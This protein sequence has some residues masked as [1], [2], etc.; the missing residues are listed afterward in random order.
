VPSARL[1]RAPACRPPGLP[2][3][4]RLR[5]GLP[6]PVRPAPRVPSRLSSR[7]LSSR[8]SF[9]LRS[10]VPSRLGARVSFRLGFR[11]PSAVCL[12]ARGRRAVPR[13]PR[14]RPSSPPSPLA[15]APERSRPPAWPS[16]PPSSCATCRCAVRCARP[17]AHAS[18]SLAA[19]T[20][21]R[22]WWP[23]GAV[24][25][26]PP[27]RQAADRP[28]SARRTDPPHRQRPRPSRRRVASR[29]RRDTTASFAPRDS[30]R[31]RMRSP[32]TAT[33]RATP[34]HAG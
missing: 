16:T 17:P 31:G 1:P 8:V 4:F 28:W 13:S 20:A 33:A 27:R 15:A 12:G 32:R 18:R 21:A 25:P 30:A 3:A 10:R 5:S 24:R 7:V 26:S 34:C 14:H 22:L 6:C 29:P 9:R 19:A 23:L 2:Y 11:V